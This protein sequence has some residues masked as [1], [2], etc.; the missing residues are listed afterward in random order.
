MSQTEK[1]VKDFQVH[2]P[3]EIYKS[4]EDEWKIGGI[5]STDDVDLHGE[6]VLQ[7]GLD[8]SVLKEGRGLFNND[9]QKGPENVLG[10]IE[11]ADFVDHNGK[12]ALM[13][14]GYL[15][16]E[17][18]RAKA[19]Y[20]IMRSVK[21]GRSARVH[22]SIEG[23][24]L[25]RD[26]TNTSKIKKARVT[27]VALTLDPVNTNTFANLV[28]SINADNE[29]AEQDFLFEEIMETVKSLLKDR[30]EKALAAGAG[31]TSAPASRTGGEAMSTES[32]DRK[33]KN[34]LWKKLKKNE[35]TQKSMLKSLIEV[36]CEAL[37]KADPKEVAKMICKSYEL[38]LKEF[39]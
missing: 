25:E 26:M 7:E 27:K 10:E 29:K 18:E 38:K 31:Y 5:A 9:H 1:F 28:K 32:M 34:M 23:K 12:K 15:F 21:K 14:K 19:Y 22:F 35:K 39:K 24:I 17:Q 37:P 11:N 16:K 3:V 30:I 8:I 4:D 20:N 6:E 2:V 13:V 33:V 36:A